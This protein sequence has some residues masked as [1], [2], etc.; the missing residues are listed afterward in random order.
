MVVYMTIKQAL[1]DY[2][3]TSVEPGEDYPDPYDEATEVCANCDFPIMKM[4]LSTGRFMSGP[5]WRTAWVHV[6]GTYSEYCYS[7]PARPSGKFPGL[8]NTPDEV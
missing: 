1:K 6:G 8:D 7:P 2:L 3:A 4:R 5:F